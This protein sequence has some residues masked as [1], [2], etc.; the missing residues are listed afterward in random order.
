MAGSRLTREEYGLAIDRQHAAQKA[1]LLKRYDNGM[2]TY[3]SE[4]DLT[5]RDWVQEAY[6]EELDR[7]AYLIFDDIAEERR[8]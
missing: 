2:A 8:L 7:I 5:S 3:G 6:E 4:P 1:Q